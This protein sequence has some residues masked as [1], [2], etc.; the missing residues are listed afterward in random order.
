MK[1]KMLEYEAEKARIAKEAKMQEEY[2]RKIRELA[3]RLKI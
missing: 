3:K 2:D 1:N